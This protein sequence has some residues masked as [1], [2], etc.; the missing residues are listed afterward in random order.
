MFGLPGK[1]NIPH[2]VCFPGRSAPSLVIMS[3]RL[4]KKVTSRAGGIGHKHSPR[5]VYFP[6]KI[7]MRP[8][9]SLKAKLKIVPII[10]K[11]ILFR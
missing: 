7:T 4:W 5:G 11:Y 1:L 3:D 6:A 10:L 8:M 2:M 9:F